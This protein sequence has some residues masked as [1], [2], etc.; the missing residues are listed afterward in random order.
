MIT[1]DNSY[2]IRELMHELVVIEAD[3][4][5]IELRINLGSIFYFLKKIKL[6]EK[7]VHFWFLQRSYDMKICP[8]IP[9]FD[10]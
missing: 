3:N 7:M 4:E 8:F 6:E 5:K 1:S 2:L 10:G 9:C